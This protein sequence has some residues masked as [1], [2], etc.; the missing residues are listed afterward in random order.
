MR[1]LVATGDVQPP[2]VWRSDMMSHQERSRTWPGARDDVLAHP[3]EEPTVK[4]AIISDGTAVKRDV[5]RWARNREARV[6]GCGGRTD[7]DSMTAEWEQ[8]QCARTETAGELS[9]ATS[10]PDEWPSTMHNSGP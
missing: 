5:K 9:A 8:Q 4:S 2:H 10:A 6:G 3:D 7:R 1:R